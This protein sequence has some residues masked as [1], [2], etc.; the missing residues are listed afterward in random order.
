MSKRVVDSPEDWDA[1][2]AALEKGAIAGDPNAQNALGGFYVQESLRLKDA[3]LLD[4]AEEWFH[5]AAERGHEEAKRFL[6][7][8]WSDTKAE[9]RAKISAR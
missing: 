4:A 6:E 5:Q 7:S 1:M 8:A 3:A 2:K 9:Y